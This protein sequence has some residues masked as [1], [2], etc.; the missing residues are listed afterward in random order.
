MSWT[1]GF[2]AALT[3]GLGIAIGFLTAADLVTL[4]F[5]ETYT[6]LGAIFET[7]AACLESLLSSVA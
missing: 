1:L 6:S 5:F 3:M 7:T 2:K 4:T